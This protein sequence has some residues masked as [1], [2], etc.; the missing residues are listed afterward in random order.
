MSVTD[1]NTAFREAPTKQPARENYLIESLWPLFDE[2]QAQGYSVEW[3]RGT[4]RYFTKKVVEE[5]ESW[6][7][8]QVRVKQLPL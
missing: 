7:H 5:G 2:L 4:Q 6:R 1:V 8:P 3:S